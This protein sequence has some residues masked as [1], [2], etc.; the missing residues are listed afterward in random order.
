[1][2]DNS[3]YEQGRM[4]DG[5]NKKSPIKL[6]KKIYIVNIMNSNGVLTLKMTKMAYLSINEIATLDKPFITFKFTN[7]IIAERRIF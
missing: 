1:M 2:V 7:N 4:F 5:G 6:Q 3:R